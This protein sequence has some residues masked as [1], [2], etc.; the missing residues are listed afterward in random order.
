MGLLPVASVWSAE[1]KS[2]VT[3]FY[4]NIGEPYR[5]VFTQIIQGIE[6]AA[7]TTKIAININATSE[8]LRNAAQ[9]QPNR[10]VIALGR[11]GLFASVALAPDTSL[12]VGGVVGVKGLMSND[13]HAMQVFSLMPEPLLLFMQLKKLMPRCQ[14]IMVVYDPDKSAWLL[15]QAELAAKQ[16]QIELHAIAVSNLKDAVTTYQTLFRSASATDDALWLPQDVTT[17]EDSIVLPL[18]LRE[19][20]TRQLLVFSSTVSHVHLGALFALYPDNTAYGRRLA[21]AAA[22]NAATAGIKIELLN[23]VLT[24]FNSNTAQHLN[25]VLNAEQRQQFD[26]IF[27]ER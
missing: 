2:S 5:A 26:L 11:Q 16:M 3:V 20:W 13:I 1:E 6:Q 17:V 23:D 8:E 4:P 7:N 21:K 9:N 10:S 12:V 14:R 24:A 25:L 19:A 27:P 22:R 18:V 15:Q